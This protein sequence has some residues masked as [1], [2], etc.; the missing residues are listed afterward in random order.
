MAGAVSRVKAGK[1]AGGDF[2]VQASIRD[3]LMNNRLIIEAARDGGLAS[4]LLD[5]CELL[6]AE[7]AGVG[8]GEADMAAVIHTIGGRAQG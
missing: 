4:P 5:A 6:Y 8:H 1:L 3:V 2:A 7:T